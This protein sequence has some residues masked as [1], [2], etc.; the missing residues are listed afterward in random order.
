MA[1]APHA[2]EP[3]RPVHDAMPSTKSSSRAKSLGLHPDEQPGQSDLLPMPA[4]KALEQP[5]KRVS[6]YELL[7]AA[8]C[9]HRAVHSHEFALRP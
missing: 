9:G 5:V 7:R 1:L 6:T 4:E 8:P 2:H 3:T